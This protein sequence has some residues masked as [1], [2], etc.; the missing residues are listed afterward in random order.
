VRH[1][2]KKHK[3]VES[4]TS[5]LSWKTIQTRESLRY[6][7]FDEDLRNEI[8]VKNYKLNSD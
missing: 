2:I 7:S 4:F 8:N 5:E 6:D 1:S 3:V